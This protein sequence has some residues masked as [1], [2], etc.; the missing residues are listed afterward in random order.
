MQIYAKEKKKRGKN[1]MTANIYRTHTCNELSEADINKTVRLAGWI[2]TIRD[3]GGV[4]FIDLR[5]HYGVTQIV[6]S[7]DNLIAG[8][9]KETV[10]SVTGEVVKRS[11]ETVNPKIQT[12]FIEIKVET[13]EILNK[14]VTNLPFE[15]RESTATREE[16]RL[17]NRFLDLRNPKVHN[18][19]IIRSKII[20]YLRKKMEEIG[21][22]EMQTPILT[23]SSPEGARDYIVPSRKHHGMFYA[24]PQAPQQFKQLLMVSGF[25]RYFQIAPCFRDEDARLDRTPGEFYQLDF[26]LAFATQDDVFA[27]KEKVMYDTFTQFSDKRVSPPPFRRIQYSESMLT[28]GTD[29]PDLRNPLIISDLTDFFRDADFKPFKTKP[30]R[31][32]VVPECG[33]NSNAFFNDLN[34]FARSIGMSAGMGYINVVENGQLKGPIAKFLSEEKQAE[35]IAVLNMKEFDTVFFICDDIKVVNRLAG[36]I[37]MEL[38][39]R[40]NLIDEN[41]YEFC[42]IVDY[43]MYEI[44][45]ETGKI[46]FAHNPFSMPQGGVDAF[47]TQAP[48]NIYAHQYDAVCNGYEMMSGAVRNHSPEIMV[49][50]FEI[51]GYDEE[52]VKT[53]FG[54]LYTAFQY[55]AP[56]HAGAAPG[57]DRIVML[58]TDEKIIREVI[59]FPMNQNA[60]DLLMNAPGPVTELQLREVH[61]K[62]R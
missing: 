56:P 42:F 40:M 30:V 25:D 19:I 60:Q 20:S 58:L 53:K 5:D 27:V 34:D 16:V 13:L 47:K 11:E 35:M 22:M 17:K 52:T 43:P 46:D 28:Y 4:V 7:N 38:G 37:R 29:K 10:I 26:E 49:K 12:G 6:I 57:V 31:G 2:D 50:A 48:L 9:G 44:N 3:H 23:S 14:S 32:I 21:F 39:W 15:I 54:G 33:K 55:G 45:E 41:R 24:L 62:I 1:S 61:I 59:A 36:Q 8:I 18:N 51:A